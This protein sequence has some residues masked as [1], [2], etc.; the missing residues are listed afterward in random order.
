MESKQGIKVENLVKHFGSGESLV[1]V[2][3]G[4]NFQVDK[5]RTCCSYCAEWGREDN[6]AYDDRLC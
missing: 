2:I 6:T 3:E 5:G 1:R 4:A